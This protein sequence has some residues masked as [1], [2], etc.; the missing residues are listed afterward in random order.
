MNRIEFEKLEGRS[1]YSYTSNGNKKIFQ[2]LRTAVTPG[3][4]VVSFRIDD[5]MPWVK[6][7]LVSSLDGESAMCFVVNAPADVRVRISVIGDVES[8]GYIEAEE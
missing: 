5:E 6:S 8:A 2:L 1:V 7:S 4:A 3:R